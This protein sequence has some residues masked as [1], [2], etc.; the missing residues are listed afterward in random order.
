MAGEAPLARLRIGVA[1]TYAA[2]GFGYASAVTALPGMKSKVG[3]DDATVSLTVLLGCVT[4]AGGSML[5]EW[6]STRRSSRVALLLGLSVQVI[7]LPLLALSP[8][9]VL[10]VAAFGIYGL[11]LGMVDASSNIQGVLVQHKAGRSVMSTFFAA[12]TGAAIAGALSMSQL[13][14]LGSQTGA[15]T[16]LLVAA[17]AIAGAVALS[18]GWLVTSGAVTFGAG[19]PAPAKAPLPTR[20]IWLFGMMVAVAFVADSAVSTWSTVYLHDTLAAGA[21]LAPLGYAAY[22]VAILATRLGGDRLVARTGRAPMVAVSVAIGIGGLVLV[23]LTHNAT[24]AVAGFALVGVGVGTLV[25][26]TFSAAGELAPARVDEVISRINLF[27]YAGAVLGAVTLGLL[28]SG[29][30][31]GPAFILPAVLLVPALVLARRFDHPAGRVRVV[32][33]VPAPAVEPQA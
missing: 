12:Y 5:A 23:A 10:F 6:V 14:H 22:Q 19:H 21:V 17:V 8:S 30:G 15:V 4:A 13:A 31:L 24:G 11:G 3:I 2:Q 18:R 33:P 16:G 29:P 7:A 9:M 28:S 27:N 25:P 32:L 1:A 26:L 20:G